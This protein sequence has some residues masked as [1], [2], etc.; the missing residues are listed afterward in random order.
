MTLLFD[1]I[2][3]IGI[4]FTNTAGNIYPPM[5]YLSVMGRR[6][7]IVVVI[8]RTLVMVRWM[9]VIVPACLIVDDGPGKGCRAYCHHG[10]SGIRFIPAGVGVVTVAAAENHQ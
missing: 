7:M 10:F 2:S 4:R 9:M 1:R 6:S 3:I 5:S 8:G